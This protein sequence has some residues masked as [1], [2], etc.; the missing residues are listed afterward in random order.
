MSVL[1]KT[2]QNSIQEALLQQHSQP[3][4]FRHSSLTTTVP[5]CRAPEIATP[6]GL[7]CP[8]HKN[9]EDRILRSEYTVLCLVLPD[10]IH[11]A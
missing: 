1:C 6:L 7:S 10:S 5:S 8:L 9:L 4:H 2:V 3:Q 11:Q